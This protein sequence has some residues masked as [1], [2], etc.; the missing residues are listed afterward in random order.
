MLRNQF[1]N[2]VFQVNPTR[3][4]SGAPCF[5]Y[6]GIN[7][8][9]SASG[10]FTTLMPPTEN[11][12]CLA[13]SAEHMTGTVGPKLRPSLY[14]QVKISIVGL[15]SVVG[16]CAP[17]TLRSWVQSEK[18]AFAQKLLVGV[19]LPNRDESVAGRRS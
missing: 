13:P 1:R 10:A 9:L 3:R 8:P 2:M 5:Q 19:A 6:L 12:T 4:G 18:N 15:G 16:R 7:R 11:S 14:R 17:I